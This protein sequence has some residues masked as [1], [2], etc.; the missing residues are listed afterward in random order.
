MRALKPSENSN[1][2]RVGTI[3]EGQERYRFGRD[4]LLKIA[5]ECNAVIRIGKSVRLDFAKMDEYFDKMGA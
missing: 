4:T 1:D 3:K 2:I 5:N